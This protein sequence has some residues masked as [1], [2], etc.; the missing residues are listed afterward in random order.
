MVTYHFL[1]SYFSQYGGM[2][3]VNEGLRMH[4]SILENVDSWHIAI[5]HC[6][7][8]YLTH[9][10]T[11]TDGMAPH[12]GGSQSVLDS[13]HIAVQ[14]ILCTLGT[15][16]LVFVLAALIFNLVFRKKR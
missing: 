6:Q 15:L 11:H 7:L 1:L 4:G 14:V 5:T 10:H 16:G 9:T 2:C 12:D 3:I 8:M 13:T